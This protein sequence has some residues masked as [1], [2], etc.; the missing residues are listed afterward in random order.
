[1]TILLC[2]NREKKTYKYVF[3]SVLYK[4]RSNNFYFKGFNYYHKDMF[5][6]VL[7]F[8]MGNYL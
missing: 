7:I 5:L 1:M 2:Q 3:F 6:T 8:L 4:S